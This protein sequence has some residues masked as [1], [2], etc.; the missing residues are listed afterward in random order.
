MRRVHGV[1]PA[2]AQQCRA[3]R[4]QQRRSSA[5]AQGVSVVSA[6]DSCQAGCGQLGFLP[7]AV[8][9][10]ACVLQGA[11]AAGSS[12]GTATGST[13]LCTCF[14]LHTLLPASLTAAVTL[15]AGTAAAAAANHLQ[16]LA[17]AAA[18]AQRKCC[19]EAQVCGAVW[20]GQ[21]AVCGGHARCAQGRGSGDGL[22]A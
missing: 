21:G 3:Y 14:V 7:A 16:R 1:R 6:R 22:R 13:P 10:A 20:Q 5:A 9:L 15:S 11:A 12:T 8:E 19:M 4:Q 17:A 18:P 2:A